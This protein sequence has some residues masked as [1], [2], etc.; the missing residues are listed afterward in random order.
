[1]AENTQLKVKKLTQVFKLKGTDLGTDL[2][3]VGEPI[4][5]YE[6]K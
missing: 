1:M 3:P 6:S 2:I 4:K 5:E